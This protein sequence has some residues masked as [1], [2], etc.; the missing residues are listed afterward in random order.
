MNMGRCYEQL[1]DFSKQNECFLL[2]D[3]FSN[4]LLLYDD[5]EVV[6]KGVENAIN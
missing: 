1:G 2:A 6:R 4:R 3:Y 5:S